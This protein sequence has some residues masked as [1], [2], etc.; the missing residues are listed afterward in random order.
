MLVFSF[1]WSQI[2]VLEALLYVV[3]H[4][5]NDAEIL[6]ER[7]LPRLQHANSAI[8]LTAIRVVLYMTNYILN[9]DIVDTLYRKLAPP[10]GILVLFYTI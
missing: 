4:D 8:V 2:Y 6:A 1:R 10:L 3:P 9:D 7:V 5:H